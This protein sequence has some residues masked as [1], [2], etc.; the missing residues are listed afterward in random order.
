MI[1]PDWPAIDDFLVHVACLFVLIAALARIVWD[2]IRKI[3]K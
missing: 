2:E 1:H 3:W